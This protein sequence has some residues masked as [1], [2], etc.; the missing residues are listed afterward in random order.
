MCGIITCDVKE[1]SFSLEG[2]QIVKR[3]HE[4]RNLDYKD[5]IFETTCFRICPKTS[6]TCGPKKHPSLANGILKMLHRNTITILTKVQLR[7]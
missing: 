4:N 2:T 1:I 3:L 7:F 5:Y 6:P